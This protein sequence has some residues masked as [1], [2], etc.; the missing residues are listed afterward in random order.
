MQTRDAAT[1]VA[2]GGPV[3]ATY[4]A[5]GVG[6]GTAE[7]V[8]FVLNPWNWWQPTTTTN[9][10]S[11]TSSTSESPAVADLFGGGIT[12]PAVPTACQQDVT[13][14][15][16]S[17][18]QA[19]ASES[20]QLANAAAL[21]RTNPTPTITL[22]S[23][24]CSRKM[25]DAAGAPA[26]QEAGAKQA[27]C[28]GAAAD[29]PDAPASAI[30]STAASPD[31]RLLPAKAAS[32]AAAAAAASGARRSALAQPGHKRASAH[33]QSMLALF[34]SAGTGSPLIPQ[35]ARRPTVAWACKPASAT[36]PVFH[37]TMLPASA[38]A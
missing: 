27:A 13:T 30:N 37:C 29:M 11:A 18:R 5:T 36:T 2:S 7:A 8:L 26:G 1:F 33:M 35:S 4:I 21:P 14:P 28:A 9:T 19:A 6:I 34:E 15:A 16:S 25:V 23:V 10:A 22:A 24:P 31:Q 32:N 20:S 3:T 38:A 12:R 17:T